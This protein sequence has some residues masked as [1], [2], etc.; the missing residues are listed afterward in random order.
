MKIEGKL[1]KE[2][3]ERVWGVSIP[4]I[5]IFTQGK[6]KSDAYKM[7]KEAIELVVELN[8][9]EVSIEPSSNN[10]FFIV[11]NNIGPILS[12]ILRQ[13]RIDNGLSIRD[14]AKR[15]G[16]SS[17]NSYGRYESGKSIPTIEKFDELLK[18]IDSNLSSILK[19]A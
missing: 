9:F 3:G 4:E 6:S 10:N 14:V 1:E 16:Q 7:A 15:M 19:V 5:G 2:P 13:K 8:D 12:M 17:P 11:P 18:A